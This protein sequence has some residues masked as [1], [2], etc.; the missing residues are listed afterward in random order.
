MQ[1]YLGVISVSLF[2]ISV[3]ILFADFGQTPAFFIMPF[4]LLSVSLTILTGIFSTKRWRIILCS[5]YGLII[6][7]FVVS[8][9][10]FGIA[11]M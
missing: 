8:A 5:L 4:F 3:F 9:L 11:H 7:I 1:K 10:G 6:L 2:V